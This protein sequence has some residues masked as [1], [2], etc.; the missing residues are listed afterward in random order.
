MSQEIGATLLPPARV[1]FFA[2]DLGTAETAQTLAKDWR[3]ARVGIDIQREGIEG[4]IARYSQSPSPEVIVVETD[5]IG[6]AFIERLGVL[7]GVCA[8]GTDAVI[9]GPQNDVHLYRD[10]VGMGVRDYLVRPISFNEIAGIIIKS[11]VEKKGLGA[12]RLVSI[13]GSK[14]GVGATAIS[15]TLAVTLSE[16]LEQK[17]VL[18]EMAGTV[19]TAG[20]ALGLEPASTLSETVRI[21]TTGTDDDLKR[22]LQKSTE[23]LC[24]L[25]SGGEAS[26][27]DRPDPDAAEGVV[28]RLMQKNPLVVV[29]LSCAAPAVQKRLISRSAHVVVVTTPV[30]AALRNARTLLSEIKSLRAG[31]G[32]VDVVVNMTGAADGF[33]VG[34]SDIARVLE[35]EP[36]V[37]FSYAP[38]T[39]L[40]AEAA[41]KPASFDR[42]SADTQKGLM[43]LAARA[44]GV[45]EKQVVDSAGAGGKPLDKFKS[46]LKKK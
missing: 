8:Q 7:A 15:Q 44:A 43:T 37:R 16:T 17:T 29:D 27:S 33:E 21:A 6:P 22:I 32:H 38:K 4:A 5:D 46:L 2:P 45:S 31:L 28:N 40:Q 20:V 19:S 13:I 36:A 18:L 34:L 9:I 26:M 10:L 12:S 14:G 11:L 24:V 25:I 39:F 3:F 30:I 42:F 41:G 1:D 35:K 23:Q